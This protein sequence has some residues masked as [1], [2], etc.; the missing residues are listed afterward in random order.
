MVGWEEAT[1]LQGRLLHK[2][3]RSS[4]TPQGDTQMHTDTQL[5]TR[6]HT[7]VVAHKH[8]EEVLQR[9]KQGET[10]GPLSLSLSL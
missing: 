9:K 8:Q 7:H 6:V 1:L 2:G 4:T 3:S 10:Q 5:Y